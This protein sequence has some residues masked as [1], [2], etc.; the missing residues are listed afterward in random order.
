MIQA[1][2]NAFISSLKKEEGKDFVELDGKINV[3]N[4]WAK[5]FMQFFRDK[6]QSGAFRVPG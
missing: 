3:N 5:E 4:D 1:S 6:T 2:V